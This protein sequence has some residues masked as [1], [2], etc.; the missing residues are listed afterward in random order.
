MSHFTKTSF[1]TTGIY[2]MANIRATG[3]INNLTYNCLE[4][5][6][7]KNGQWVTLEFMVVELMATVV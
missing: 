2:K 6:Q 3:Y 7:G 4:T 5:S 1:S